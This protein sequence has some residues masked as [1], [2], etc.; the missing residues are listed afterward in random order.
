MSTVPCD[1]CY[2]EVAFSD[3]ADHLKTHNHPIL[4]VN[5]K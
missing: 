5:E 1:I 3:F 2:Q 4:N